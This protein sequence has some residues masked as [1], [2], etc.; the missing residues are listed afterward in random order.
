MLYDDV[1][2]RLQAQAFGGGTLVSTATLELMATAAVPTAIAA[3]KL[4]LMGIRVTTVRFS[5]AEFQAPAELAVEISPET[6]ELDYPTAAPETD[7]TGNGDFDVR[8]ALLILRF[9]SL[10]AAPLLL[11]DEAAARER[12]GQ[13]LP[14]EVLDL[15]LDIDGD[16]RVNALDLRLLLR[17]LAGLR[18][19]AVAESM[20]AD[21][22]QALLL[23]PGS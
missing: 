20:R 17:Y 4:P 22:L 16:G 6:L 3:A 8:D 13:L 7:I 1:M 2:L 18:G 11:M 14:P 23:P 15:R 10:P 12:L 5:V 19:S 9:M 21:R